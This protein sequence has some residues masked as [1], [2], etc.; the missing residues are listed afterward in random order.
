MADAIAAD[1]EH[2]LNE[3]LD[4]Y[5]VGQGPVPGRGEIATARRLRLQALDALAQLLAHMDAERARLPKL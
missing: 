4:R 5:C 3:A 2:A 1:H